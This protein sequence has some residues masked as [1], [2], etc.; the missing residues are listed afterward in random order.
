[1]KFYSLSS[2]VA[3]HLLSSTDG[4]KL[5]IPFELTE[6]EKEIIQFPCTSF[7]LGRSGTGKTT[8]LTMKLMQKE[9]R[10]LIACKGLGF[11]EADLSGGN[12][13]NS[14]VMQKDVRIEQGFIRQIFL[15]VSSKLCSSVKNQISRLKRFASDDFFD[16]PSRLQ[17]HNIGDDNEEF[18]YIPDSFSNIPQTNYPLAI[19]FRKFLIM[20]HETLCTSFFERFYSQLRTFN[21]VGK[22]KSRA[23]QAYMATK[24]VD[25][26][27]FSCSYWPHFNAKLAKDLD[28]STVFTQIISHIKGGNQA[29]KS[30]DGKLEK[31]DYIMLFDRRFPSLSTE[32]RDEIYDIYLCYEEKIARGIDFRFEDIH[33]FF[34]TEFHPNAKHGK[35]LHNVIM[36]ILW[37]SH[38][39]ARYQK[40]YLGHEQLLKK[41]REIVQKVSS[42]YTFELNPVL[43]DSHDMLTRNQMSPKSLIYLWNCWKSVVFKALSRDVR[44]VPFQTAGRISL[45]KG[46]SRCHSNVN[47][48]WS[49]V[50]NYW[51]NEFYSV[52]ISVLNKLESLA[53]ICSKQE[54]HPYVQGLIV[55]AIHEIAKFLRDT[56][57]SGPKN[58]DKSRDFFVLDERH[59]NTDKFRNFCVLSEDLLFELVFH[60]WND[61]T[62]T[63]LYILN[64]P[65]AA[66]LLL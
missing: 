49:P 9:Q 34:Y 45:P 58:A 65:T 66:E 63:L 7:I 4:S 41:A 38:V 24:E 31:Q 61:E 12:D 62:C 64:I 56:K 15:T 40:G 39:K 25:Y 51:T 29:S 57:F 3:N 44:H 35:M 11:E 1:M 13:N 20:L 19:T 32:M 60:D 52:G 28:A 21:E 59:N 22:S 55:L 14:V 53:R 26:E 43:G 23:L 18:N 36:N 2:G 42:A 30:P 46:S 48:D 16:R 17:M 27:K 6:Q 33:S 37:T 54:M 47:Q 50:W 5:D 10:Y 8:V